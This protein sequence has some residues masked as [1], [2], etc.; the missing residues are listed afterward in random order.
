MSNGQLRELTNEVEIVGTLKS[1][2]CEHFTSKSLD[3]YLKVTAVIMCKEDNKIHEHTVK[4]FAK[5]GSKPYKSLE[6]V[7]TQYRAEDNPL[8]EGEPDRVRVI[9]KLKFNEYYNQNKSKIVE[10]NE[11]QG[12]FF[13][14]LKK[15]DVSSDTAIAIIGTVIDNYVEEIINQV[16]TGNYLVNC[17]TIGYN[18]DYIQLCNVVISKELASEFL[19]FYEPGKTGVLTYKINNYVELEKSNSIQSNHGF[20]SKEKINNVVK[21][22]VNNLEIIGGDLPLMPPEE[23]TAEEI[24]DAKKIHELKLQSFNTAATSMLKGFKHNNKN[25]DFYPEPDEFDEDLPF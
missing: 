17:F 24:K 22:Y 16:P 6:T 8:L 3:E 15:D 25:N 21:K 7:A 14:R 18:N 9:G 1:L 4:A 20:G 10:F 23:Y 19:N 11:I 12:S 2:E 5:K 13:N